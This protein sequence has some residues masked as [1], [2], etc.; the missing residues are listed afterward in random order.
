MSTDYNF[1]SRRSTVMSSRGMVAS[2]QPLA[3]EAGIRMLLQGGNAVDAA[4]ATAAALNVVEP[5]S[6]G[7]GGDVFTLLYLKKTKQVIA[8]N[9]SGRAPGAANVETLHKLGY[10]KM[11]DHGIHSVTV[12]GCLDA[13]IALL[14]NHGTMSLREILSPAIELAEYGFPISEMVGRLWQQ[15]SHLLAHD[16]NASLTFMPG[17]RVPQVGEIFRQPYLASTFKAIAAGGRD[18]FYNGPI[19]EAIV[20]CSEEHDGLLSIDDLKSHSSTWVD[21][22]STNYRGYD[23]Y[24]C[25]PNCQG[26]VTLMCLNILEGYDLNSLGYDSADY[27]HHI[28]EA[29]KLAFA[30]A[31][32]YI[33]DPEFKEI[34]LNGLLSK[35]YSTQ[36]RQSISSSEAAKRAEVGVPAKADTVYVATIDE[37]GNSV[38]LI[39]SIFNSF[40]SG[41]V[42]PNTGICLQNRGSSFSLETEHP[43]HLEPHKR[44]YHTIMPGMVLRNSDLFLTFGVTGAF[45]Q[46]QGQLQVLLNI[47]NFGMDVQTALD[48]PRFRYVGRN[49]VAFEPGF[50]PNVLADFSKKGHTIVNAE[51]LYY[52]EFG[53]GQAIMVHPSTKAFIGGSEPRRDGCAIGI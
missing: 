5:M 3:V 11:P 13:W 8:L 4:V 36:R 46:P 24:E 28:T 20:Q 38:S 19:A 42:V 12:P 45:M 49:Q 26:L 50:S 29:I 10:T 22:I 48:A 25:P 44:P 23:V 52:S 53:S 14:E 15:N 27:I 18:V 31:R 9:G 51:E 7:I 47:I 32:H 33:T 35:P 1:P 34:P 37:E 21:P 16:K 40:G 41:V 2:S 39:N 6:T 30:D 17:G 43:N